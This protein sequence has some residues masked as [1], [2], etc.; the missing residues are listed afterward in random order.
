MNPSEPKS[1]QI[2]GGLGFVSVYDL[3]QTQPPLNPHHPQ[4]LL[5][6]IPILELFS[7]LME[8][9]LTK[10]SQIHPPRTENTHRSHGERG[11]TSASR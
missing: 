10:Y 3:N 4:K 6:K 1:P 11:L 9:K 2:C 7:L 8:P 5:P